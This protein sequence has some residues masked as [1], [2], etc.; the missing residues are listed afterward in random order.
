MF[1]SRKLCIFAILSPFLLPLALLVGSMG[2][3]PSEASK[4]I[5]SEAE[6]VP[7][8][9]AIPIA[10]P[11]S[12]LAFING[13]WEGT[14]GDPLGWSIRFDCFAQNGIQKILA[15]VTSRDFQH[16]YFP[17]NY[18]L[19]SDGLILWWNDEDNRQKIKL[20]FNQ[21]GQLVGELLIQ[22]GQQKIAGVFS[23]TSAT[24]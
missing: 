3:K 13:A 22:Q 17:V 12:A 14:L 24:P 11:P 6:A 5:V 23:K 21:S 8:P 2:C 9:E 19:E 4:P 10:L 15:S 7:K 16:L 1:S 20:Q 18:R